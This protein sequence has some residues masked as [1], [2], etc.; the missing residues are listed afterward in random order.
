MTLLLSG[1]GSA[2]QHV[3]YTSNSGKRNFIS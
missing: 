2:Q 1:D 3:H